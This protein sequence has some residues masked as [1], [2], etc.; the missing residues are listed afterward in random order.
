MRAEVGLLPLLCPTRRWQL[1]DR[2]SPGKAASSLATDEASNRAPSAHIHTID[3]LLKANSEHTFLCLD[4]LSLPPQPRKLLS[5][6]SSR[7]AYSH[8]SHVAKK[9]FPYTATFY[10]L[11][12]LVWLICLLG[13]HSIIN[14]IEHDQHT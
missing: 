4:S 8:V 1:Q 13:N 10:F 9:V 11:F 3:I 12:F 2:R 6:P 5:S 7:H 14:F